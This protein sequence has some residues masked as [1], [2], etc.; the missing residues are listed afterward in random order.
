M[1][2]KGKPKMLTQYPTVIKAAGCASCMEIQR[3]ESTAHG[4]IPEP[5]RNVPIFQAFIVETRTHRSV[6]Q[7]PGVRQSSGVF[8]ASRTSESSRGLEHSRT[9]RALDAALC[10]RRIEPYAAT[11]G[12]SKERED[13]CSRRSPRWLRNSQPILTGA[14]DGPTPWAAAMIA[15]ATA[16]RGGDRADGEII[17]DHDSTEP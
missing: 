4:P 11:A 13:S 9:L 12:V 6:R 17:S 1:K 14:K 5:S 10:V 8:D 2:S 7:R 15:V 16:P 3:S